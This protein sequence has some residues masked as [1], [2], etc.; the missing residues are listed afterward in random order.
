MT[1]AHAQNRAVALF[2]MLLAGCCSVPTCTWTGCDP[3][4]HNF[5][6]AGTD[7]FFRDAPIRDTSSLDVGRDAPA[8][9]DPLFPLTV[10][11]ARPC[12]PPEV[13]I[14]RP[15]ELP[16][17]ATPRVLWSRTHA[18][19]GITGRIANAGAVDGL[20]NLHMS[21]VDDEHRAFVVDGSGLLV[22]R[23]LGTLGAGPYGPLMVSSDAWTME[24]STNGVRIDRPLVF[25]TY[26]TIEPPEVIHDVHL[27]A[28]AGG[29]YVFADG[30]DTLL[31]YC[32]DLFEPSY[33]TLQWSM[34][35]LSMGRN[36]VAFVLADDSIWMRGSPASGQRAFRVSVNG[37]VIEF[38]RSPTSAAATT[39]EFADDL[40]IIRPALS[41]D[42]VTMTDGF[43]V[44]ARTP[45]AGPYRIDPSASIWTRNTGGT[46][47]TRFDRGLAAAQTPADRTIDLGATYAFPIGEDGS[48]LLHGG[49]PIAPTL[50][51][52]LSD[53]TI[54]WELPVPGDFT[55]VTHDLDGRVYLYGDGIIMAVQ[56]DV[57]PPSVR[58]CWQHRCSPA[59]DLRIE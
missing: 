24:W 45:V 23:G 37:D 19:L 36:D 4:R 29:F 2:G 9:V 5:I 30:Y 27:A 50:F 26:G 44:L 51:R 31:H 34:R 11:S 35:G 39:V 14:P 20:G 33:V 16:A 15:R 25:D 22:G 28:T 10:H 43:S 21:D 40:T 17:D 13:L 55:Y 46:R 6:D 8:F 59:G 1:V 42:L 57:L 56:T 41:A 47:W 38:A 18:E 32:L 48:F 54:A 58:G 52:M 49:T 7:A 12:D 53:G 3:V